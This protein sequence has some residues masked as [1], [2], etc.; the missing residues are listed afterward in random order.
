MDVVK[1]HE[2]P[3]VAGENASAASPLYK[4]GE[5]FGPLRWALSVH[6]QPTSLRIRPLKMTLKMRNSDHLR[7]LKMTLKIILSAILSGL[8]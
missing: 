2:K 1:L 7:P 6:F 4:G 8:N 5:V 3:L